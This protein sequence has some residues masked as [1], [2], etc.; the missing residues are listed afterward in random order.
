M[1]KSD[2]D[3]KIAATDDGHLN[4]KSIAEIHQPWGS[5]PPQ[6]QIFYGHTKKLWPGVKVDKRLS[7]AQPLEMSTHHPIIS[8]IA[9]LWNSVIN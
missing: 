5:F 6:I 7:R 9:I 3:A 8:F 2:N 1:I 4:K